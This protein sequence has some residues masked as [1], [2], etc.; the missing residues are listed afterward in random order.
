MFK[1]AASAGTIQDS[2]WENMVSMTAMICE[3]MGK[4]FSACLGTN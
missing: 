4:R 3:I 1:L 2:T